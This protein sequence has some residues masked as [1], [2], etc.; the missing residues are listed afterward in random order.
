MR[1]LHHTLYI[2]SA[3]VW[4]LSS[5]SSCDTDV[6]Y[7]TYN[8][9]Q[10]EGWEKNDTLVFDV[11]RMLSSGR[12]RLE[13]GMRTTGA[14]P[15]TGLSVVV[16]QTVIPGYRTVTDTLRCRLSDDKG[17]ILGQGVSCFQYNFILSDINLRKGD[18]LHVRVRHIMKREILPGISDV[19]L[20][21]IRK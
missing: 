13:M 19:G 3:A 17:N 10:I 6:V 20:K 21:V 16:E 8:H 5:F 4:L 12:Y 9:T 18:S 14:F 2:L 15:F 11:P 1:R 7:D